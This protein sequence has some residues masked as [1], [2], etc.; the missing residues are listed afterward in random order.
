MLE[1]RGY[2]AFLCVGVAKEGDE[3][4]A[5]AWVECSGVAVI[6]AKGN[7]STILILPGVSS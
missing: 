5:H 6:G 2:P 7:F 4:R 1:R 3:L